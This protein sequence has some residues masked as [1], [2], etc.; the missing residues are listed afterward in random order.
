MMLGY[1]SQI[2][3]G[4]RLPNLAGKHASIGLG[5]AD[6]HGWLLL[7]C[8]GLIEK[9]SRN[10]EIINSIKASIK[11]IKN[12]NPTSEKIKDYIKK[13]SLIINKKEN[14]CH[15][16]SFEIESALEKSILNLLKFH[17]KNTFEINGRLETWMDTSVD[18]DAREGIR[19]EIQ[20][21]RLNMY[22]LMFE[23][24]RDEKYRILENLLKNNLKNKFWN[25]EMLAD[26][27]G[28]FTA[29]PNV[30]IAAYAYQ[31][32]LANQEWETCFNNILENLWL[33]WG[34]LST[35]DKNNPLFT[36][37]STGED[38]K[39][40]HRG[41]SWFWIN[42]LAALVFNRINKTKFNKQIKKIISASTEEILWKGCIGCHSELSSAKELRSEGCF[43]QAW[44]NAMFVELI[45]EVF[46]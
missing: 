17:T 25:G 15:S 8:N 20:A 2:G 31:E 38:T 10:K 12:L 33:D 30:F 32:L 43:N 13:C 6:A 23:I 16:I 34:G 36:N 7:R 5:N 35:I 19:I 1:L 26:G 40:Y 21:L 44:S 22:R 18:G 9:A 27:I 29:R 14:D 37:E 3:N 46:K 11:N 24:T 39:S 28:D 41:D 42:N 4:G 45:D